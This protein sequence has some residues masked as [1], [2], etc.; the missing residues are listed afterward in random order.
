MLA[1][2]RKRRGLRSGSGRGRCAAAG[3]LSRLVGV[4]RL[5]DGGDILDADG[6]RDEL[7]ADALE[8][9]DVVQVG[10]AED[11]D[12]HLVDVLARLARV[13]KGEHAQEDFVAHVGDGDGRVGRL[14]V[15]GREHPAKV[16]GAREEDEL[17]RVQ[18]APLDHE[19]DVR[20]LWVVDHRLQV[21]REGEHCLLLGL[22]QSELEA[23]V[24]VAAAVVAA[25]DEERRAVHHAR[26][27]A[28]RRGR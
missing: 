22:L 3:A 11:L 21:A 9:L 5:Q 24:K 17:V 28:P 10:D 12:G 26:V 19:G 15:A 1:S 8:R 6:A 18:V 4:G 23:V 13:Q 16:L 20:E 2:G 14:A 25:E 7:G 27:R